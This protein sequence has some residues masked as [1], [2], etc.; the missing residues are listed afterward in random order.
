[1]SRA[2]RRQPVY[3]YS[4][5]IAFLLQSPSFLPSFF[6]FPPSLFRLP[7]SSI[8]LLLPFLQPIFHF[9]PNPPSL[10]GVRIMAVVVAAA[11]V[12][13]SSAEND[14]LHAI[15]GDINWK[16]NVNEYRIHIIHPR[17]SIL[18]RH[19]LLIHFQ[20]PGSI[21]ITTIAYVGNCSWAPLQFLP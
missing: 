10:L 11:V 17:A 20:L 3:K 18:G 14:P 5:Y 1:M 16:T 21:T 8:D 12:T 6:P 7:F 15:C 13:N 2:A 9:P 19:Q 4:V